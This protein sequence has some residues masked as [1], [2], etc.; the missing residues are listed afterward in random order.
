MHHKSCCTVSWNR[1]TDS[2]PGFSEK[3]LCVYAV[4]SCSVPVVLINSAQRSIF[5]MLFISVG[6]AGDVSGRDIHSA[7]QIHEYGMFGYVVN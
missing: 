4:L 6:S 1:P 7:A 3:H 2:P 5:A